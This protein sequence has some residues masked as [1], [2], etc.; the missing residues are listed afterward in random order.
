MFMP[1]KNTRPKP[2]PG[3][4]RPFKPGRKKIEAQQYN[5]E[6]IP[7]NKKAKQDVVKPRFSGPPFKI[8]YSRT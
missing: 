3:I 7:Y 2:P 6:A 1:I 4:I 8:I 5:P